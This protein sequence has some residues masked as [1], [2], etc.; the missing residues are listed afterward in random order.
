MVLEGP[1]FDP[2]RNLEVFKTFRVAHH[3]LSWK[4]G[5]DFFHRSL[6]YDQGRTAT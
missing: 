2:L 4:T 1:L 3:T 5:V 6:L